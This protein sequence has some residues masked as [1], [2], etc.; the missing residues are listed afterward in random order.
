[1]DEPTSDLDPAD[2]DPRDPAFRADPIPWYRALRQKAPVYGH[3]EIGV[4]LSRYEDI[5][6]VLRDRRFGVATP[7]PWREVFAA[8]A[9]PSMHLLSENSLLFIDPPQHT[10]V[11]GLVAQAFTPRRIEAL[12][13]RIEA[14]IDGVLDG[15]AGRPTFDVL[16]EVAWPLPIMAVTDLLDVPA[17]DQELLHRW[18]HA[19]A[20]VDELPLEFELLPAAGVAA[21]EFLAY[22]GDLVDERRRHP[23][24]DLISGLIAAEEDGRT[25]SRDELLSMIVLILLA[26]HDTTASL[27]ST[28]LWLLLAHPDQA[29]EVRN[30]PGVV[31][32]A[33]EEVLRYL[34]PLQVASGGGRWPDEPVT[35]ED[36]V[37][38]PGTPVRLLLG[39]AN[40]DPAQYG[41]PDAF[42]IHRP[43]IRHLAFGRGLHVCLGSALGRLEAQEVVPAVLRR[44][45]DLQLVDDQPTWRPSFVVRQL[46]ALPV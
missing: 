6:R 1:M 27:I 16:E 25:L 39:S 7:S 32:N 36:T 11:R 40:R 45:P 33:I 4:V 20:A 10:R 28:A 37:I 43:S 42:D 14:M 5:D 41:D 23:G 34:G 29:D 8:G 35:I 15:L 17:T 24:D 12:R 38:E 44:F 30:D 46:A 21:D 2:W 31:P 13:P 9:P 26:G 22:A 3:E 18:T 19:I